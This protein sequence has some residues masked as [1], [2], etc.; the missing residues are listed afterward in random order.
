MARG[1]RAGEFVKRGPVG[2]QYS[3]RSC[4]PQGVLRSSSGSSNGG[5]ERNFFSHAL[6][7]Q[8][9]K[10][11]RCVPVAVQEIRDELSVEKPRPEVLIVARTKLGCEKRERPIRGGLSTWF[12]HKLGQMGLQ[13]GFDVIIVVGTVAFHAHCKQPTVI[14]PS[15]PHIPVAIYRCRRPRTPAGSWSTRSL[16]RVSEVSP[17]WA[18]SSC[19]IIHF[20]SR[21]MS[22][23]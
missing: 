18:C 15:A 20:L 22:R 23:C 10:E 4:S 17:R 14:F 3:A 5:R 2:S 11:T 9:K 1:D 6:V 7:K 12:P 19:L 16:Q 13:R 21:R 8:K